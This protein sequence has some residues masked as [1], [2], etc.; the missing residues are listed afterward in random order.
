MVLIIWIFTKG[1]VIGEIIINQ[2]ISVPITSLSRDSGS[3]LTESLSELD[4]GWAW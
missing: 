4:Q 2:M 3:V 1:D